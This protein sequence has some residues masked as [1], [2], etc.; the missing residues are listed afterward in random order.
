MLFVL[1]HEIIYVLNCFW[2][3]FL[4]FFFRFSHFVFV[5]LARDFLQK[6]KKKLNF[7]WTLRIGMSSYP[8]IQLSDANILFLH[9][10]KT[11]SPTLTVKRSISFSFM[12]IMQI[13]RHQFIERNT[14]KKNCPHLD[15]CGAK[16]TDLQS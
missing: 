6:F 1:Q 9:N 16:M 15:V 14:I 11:Y 5:N 3:F 4:N 12:N 13:T 8:M 7:I 10:L 2:H